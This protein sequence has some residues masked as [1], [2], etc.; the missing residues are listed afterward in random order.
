MGLTLLVCLFVVL[1]I[2]FCL[3]GVLYYSVPSEKGPSGG[4]ISRTV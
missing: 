4:D 2:L 3:F 1:L